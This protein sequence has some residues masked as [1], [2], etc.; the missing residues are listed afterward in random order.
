MRKRGQQQS[1]EWQ[2]SSGFSEA[3]LPEWSRATVLMAPAS[4]RNSCGY[5]HASNVDSKDILEGLAQHLQATTAF[6]CW[7]TR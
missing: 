1:P 2:L 5:R 4:R 3:V 6:M 7:K